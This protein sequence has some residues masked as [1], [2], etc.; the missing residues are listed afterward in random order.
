MTARELYR[1]LEE[2]DLLDRRLFVE[3]PGATSRGEV[4][5]ARVVLDPPSNPRRDM[6]GTVYV[7]A[8]DQQTVVLLEGA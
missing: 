3:R 7:E 5:V 8:F 6:P 1:Y 4:I 2:R